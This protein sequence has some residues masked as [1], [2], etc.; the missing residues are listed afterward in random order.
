MLLACSEK[1]MHMY[2][3]HLH[4]IMVTGTKTAMMAIIITV[5]TAPTTTAG[6]MLIT[7]H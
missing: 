3:I 5:A 6:I 2:I 7:V 1:I 4:N